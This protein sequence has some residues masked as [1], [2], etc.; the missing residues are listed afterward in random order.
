MLLLSGALAGLATALIGCFFAK[1]LVE[2]M[3][4]MLDEQ[5]D[6]LVAAFQEEIPMAGMFLKGK[7]LEKLRGKADQKLAG[8]FPKVKNKINSLWIG[9]AGAFIGLFVGFLLELVIFYFR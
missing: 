7:M 2:R 4:P 1:W 6:Q 9:V 5:V 3:R 8:L